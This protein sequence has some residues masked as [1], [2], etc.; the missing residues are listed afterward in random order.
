VVGYWLCTSAPL[1]AVLEVEDAA[2]ERDFFSSWRTKKKG[3]A[4]AILYSEAS[5][6]IDDPVEPD[7]I[8]G[9]KIDDSWSTASSKS[10]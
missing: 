1:P 4:S 8:E 6:Y 10:E 2:S 9:P 5:W 7:A 3:K